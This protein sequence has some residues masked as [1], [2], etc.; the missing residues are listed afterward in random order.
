MNLLF[1][2]TSIIFFLLSTTTFGKTNFLFKLRFIHN[3]IALVGADRVRL[4]EITSLTLKRGEYTTG[5][6]SSPVPQLECVGGTAY[7]K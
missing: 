1:T 4:R 7:G 6:R 2:S 5:R 3:M